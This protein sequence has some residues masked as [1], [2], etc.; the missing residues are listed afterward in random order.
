MVGFSGAD[1]DHSD[2]LSFA[3]LTQPG[4][5]TVTNNN[6]GTFSF[7]PGSAFQDLSEGESRE[8]SFTYVAVDDS[9]AA[10]DTSEEQTVTITVTGT[11]DLPEV[12]QSISAASDEDAAPFTVSLLDHA[13]DADSSAQLSVPLYDITLVSGDARGVQI[14]TSELLVKPE[15]YNHLAEGEQEVI[16]YSYTIDDGQ[17]GSVEQSASITVAGTNDL[18][19]VS[20]AIAIVSSEDSDQIQI[21]LLS[22]ATDVDE[23]DVLSLQAGSLNL[24][25][26]DDSGVGIADNLLTIE[27]SPYQ[28]LLPGESNLLEYSYTIEDGNG[29]TVVQ[30][31]V[32]T[33][34]GSNDGPQVTASVNAEASE[35][36]STFSVDMLSGVTDVDDAQNL[37]VSNLSLVSGDDQGVTV[38]GNQLQ[39]DP[40]FYQSLAEGESESLVY[41]FDVEDGS[42]GSISQTAAIT[43]LGTNDAPEVSAQV[44]ATAGDQDNIFTVDLLEHA[45][46]IDA[47]DTLS[48]L[49]DSISLSGGN[50]AGIT[51]NG[52][53]LS[54]NPA[55]YRYL[56]E[57]EQENIRYD[58]TVSDGKGGTVPQSV[59]ITVDGSND[60]PVVGKRQC[61]NG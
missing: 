17:G 35:D 7:E 52:N 48:V 18:P 4:E 47:S 12:S 55:A 32:I 37:S 33:I 60:Q 40:S 56:A 2:T 5:G 10:N 22:H 42:G 23:S 54:V 13:T 45:F 34:T 20:S 36:D 15:S 46:D 29:G 49:T 50:G 21:D 25:S 51:V 6:D 28:Y 1:E 14:G 39:V 61:S 59:M 9:G 31:A 24:L 44:M 8:V 19:T 30:K 57:G 58:Y 43:L 53:T 11:N 27:L 3:I 38:S 16:V 26:G 41:V